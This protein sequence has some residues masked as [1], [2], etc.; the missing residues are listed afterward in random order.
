MKLLINPF[1]AIKKETGEA[2]YISM[3][4][5]RLMQ[6]MERAKEDMAAAY[7]NFDNVTDPDLI[8]CYIYEVNAVLKRYKFLIEQAEKLDIPPAPD[9]TNS[10]SEEASVAS[11]LVQINR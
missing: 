2:I 1:G 11:S 4:R 10:L 8:D 5:Q 9:F 7:A 3:E 6:D